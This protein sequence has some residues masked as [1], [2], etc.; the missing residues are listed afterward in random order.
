MIVLTKVED[1]L[2][3]RHIESHIPKNYKVIKLPDDLFETHH[4]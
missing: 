4:V 1:V 3:D 2:E